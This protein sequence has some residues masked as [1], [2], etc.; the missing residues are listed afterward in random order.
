[1]LPQFSLVTPGLYGATAAG[2]HALGPVHDA[3]D[4]TPPRHWS[5]AGW[6]GGGAAERVFRPHRWSE[7]TP[8]GNPPLPL[9][10]DS[11]PHKSSKLCGSA[12][13]SVRRPV[14]GRAPPRATP[15][16]DGL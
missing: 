6:G 7:D 12:W 15:G 8:A 5:G 1:M 2:R 9:P 16:A 14:S 11:P 13:T 4:G 10:R 3:A